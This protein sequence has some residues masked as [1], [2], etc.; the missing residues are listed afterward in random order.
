MN[1]S[2]LLDTHVLIWW[3]T[4]PRK[5]STATR[6]LIEE[7]AVSVSVLTMWEIAVKVGHGRLSP[8]RG[9]VGEAVVDQGF[10]WLALK[11]SHVESAAAIGAEH[12]DPVDR[13]LVGTARAERLCF[14]TRD[15]ALIEW[16]APLLGPLLLE[17]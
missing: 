15:A 12:G 2:L 11:R 13:L 9:D 6:R 8:P 14:V 3:L 5:L 10:A 7:G 16:S 1:R 4:N 17:A